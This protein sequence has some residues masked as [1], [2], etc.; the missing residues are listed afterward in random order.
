[1]Y[2]SREKKCTG[3]KK[4]NACSWMKKRAENRDTARLTTAPAASSCALKFHVSNIQNTKH[5]MNVDITAGNL[6]FCKRK[7]LLP[8]FYYSTFK[9]S[10]KN[11]RPAVIF[12][13]VLRHSGQQAFFL[14]AAP[15]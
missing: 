6:V 7:P 11:S 8:V 1:M 5:T 13:A 2:A 15:S 4:W 12:I 3:L 10:T 9:L 14:S